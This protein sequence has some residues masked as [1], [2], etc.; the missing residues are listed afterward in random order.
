M[1]KREINSRSP[2]I[3]KEPDIIEYAD[4]TDPDAMRTRFTEA[5][6]RESFNILSE[7]SMG[8]LAK[9]RSSALIGYLK[10]LNQLEELQKEKLEDLS[11]EDLEK[12]TSD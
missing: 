1:S 3:I 12:A 5:L 7:A 11:D 6:R 9:D 10:Y 2:K 4:D 8:A